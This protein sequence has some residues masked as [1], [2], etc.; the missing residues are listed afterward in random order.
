METPESIIPEEDIEKVHAIL[1][2]DN[3]LCVKTQD[4]WCAV[5]HKEQHNF[6]IAKT[7]CGYYVT[8]PM[9]YDQRKP[10]CQECK[11]HIQKSITKSH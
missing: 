11:K 10:T 4:G 6:D 9:G 5:D 7:K 8:F 2:E 3:M 1:C